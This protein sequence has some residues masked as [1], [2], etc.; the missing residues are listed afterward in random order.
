M[1]KLTVEQTN[2]GYILVGKFNDSEIKTKIVIEEK[3]EE[4]SD[5][6]AMQELLWQIKEYFGVYN[7]KHNKKNLMIEIEDNK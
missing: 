3:D 4:H 2:N 7:S 6:L 1:Q 5:L